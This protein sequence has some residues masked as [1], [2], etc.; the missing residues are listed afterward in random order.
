MTLKALKGILGAGAAVA[1]ATAGTAAN[2]APD[3][4]IQ[5]ADSVVEFVSCEAS[6]PLVKGRIVIRNE[7]NSEANLRGAGEFFRSFVAVYVP[8]NIDLI[9]KDTSRSKI[10]PG[11]QRAVTFSVGRNKTKRGRNYNGYGGS[12]TAGGLP[13]D[14]DALD[15]DE[16]LARAVQQF[17]K[18]RLYSISVDGAWGPGSRRALAAFQKSAGLPG[19]G[20]WNGETAA[21][22]SSLMPGSTQ[23]EVTN[24]K[25]EQGRTKIT[26]FAVVDPYNLIDESNE[27]NNILT[28]T[29]YVECD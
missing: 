11:E 28:Y 22:I 5:G 6:Q 2:A 17:L 10:E 1:L 18:D 19:G 14:A 13:S 21:A 16:D 24:E 3:L 27:K 8:E 4:V 12:A 29:G 15:N 25:D 7:G 20:E 23:V 9:D 26:V